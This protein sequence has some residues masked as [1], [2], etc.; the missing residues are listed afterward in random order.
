MTDHQRIIRQLFQEALEAAAPAPA[1]KRGVDERLRVDVRGAEN[2]YILG[3]GKAGL[4]MLRALESSFQRPADAGSMAVPE[5]TSRI[6]GDI[7]LFEAGHPLPDEAS[8]SAG[9]RM[10][11]IAD[12]AGGEDIV[13]CPISGGGSALAEVSR[14]EISLENIREITELLLNAGLSIHEINAVRRHLSLLKGDS[15]PNERRRRGFIPC[16]SPMS[17][18]TISVPSPPAQRRL[19]RLRSEMRYG[20]YVRVI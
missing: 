4:P 9:E 18:G 11:E 13:I 20:S 16:W 14:S 7:E 1:V 15:W 5:T 12:S 17:S 10:L 6:R 19:T 3:A 2:L 8:L